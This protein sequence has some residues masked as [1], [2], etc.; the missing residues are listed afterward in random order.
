MERGEDK[1]IYDK[2][3]YRRMIPSKIEFGTFNVS[4]KRHGFVDVI[5]SP[6]E[7]S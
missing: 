4:V 3:D 1:N 5:I 6:S 2:K 7:E